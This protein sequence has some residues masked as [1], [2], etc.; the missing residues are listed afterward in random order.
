MF[1]FLPPGKAESV[2]KQKRGGPRI[3]DRLLESILPGV[4]K[5]RE[6]SYRD[7]WGSIP[8]EEE[9]IDAIDE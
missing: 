6:T 5:P 3:V 4:A 1:S 2:R 7:C 9:G 8:P